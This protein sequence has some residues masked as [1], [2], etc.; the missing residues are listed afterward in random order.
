M[1]ICS[2]LPS[3]TEI[4]CA[5]GLGDALVGVTYECDY[6]PEVRGKTVVVE[7]RLEA[8]G[9]TAAEL[10]AQVRAFLARGESLYRVDDVALRRLQPDLILTQ[11]LCP[12][13]AASP[14]D[15][16]AVLGTF[17]VSPRVLTLTPKD[18]SGVWQDILRIGEAV[19]RSQQ[20]SALVAELVARV[21]RVRTAVAEAPRPR[22]LALE[23][24]DPPFLPGHWV[25]EMLAIAGGEPLG[26][27]PGEP[28]RRADWVELLQTRPDV[29]LLMP[30]GYDLAATCAEA[31][32]LRW[33]PAWWE[34]PAVR[35]GHVWALDAN[36]YFARPGPRLAEGLEILAAIL[37]PE[38]A[39]VPLRAAVAAPVFQGVS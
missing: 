30:C 20:A 9:R 7:T 34:L 10:D 24:L 17:P 31:R 11:D 16:P 23:W 32:A 22:V 38:R 21:E 29:I 39:P 33:P 13:C 3:A 8:R 26:C 15:L 4:V 5:L 28:S 19:G 27:R 2:F 25:P 18:L 35:A 12:V 1:R 6:P 37:H 14:E 36:S